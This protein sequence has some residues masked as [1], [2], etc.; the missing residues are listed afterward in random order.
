MSSPTDGKR[1]WGEGL[2]VA[3]IQKVLAVVGIVGVAVLISVV[4]WQLLNLLLLAFGGIMAAVLFHFLGSKLANTTRLPY[5]AALLTVAFGL[6]LFVGVIIGMTGPLLSNQFSDIST[7][8]GRSLE[9][10]R[11]QIAQWPFGERLVQEIDKFTGPDGFSFEQLSKVGGQFLGILSTTLGT[12]V[13]L[14]L[15]FLLGVYL[16]VEPRLYVGGILRLVPIGHRTRAQEVLDRLYS[17]LVYWFF[18]QMVSL[19]LIG[20]GM[21][22]GLYVL[23][24]PLALFLGLLTAMLTFIPNLGPTLAAVPVMLVALS[25]GPWTALYALIFVI[26]LQNAEGIFVTP[27]ILRRAVQLP[28]ALV[29]TVQICLATLAGFLG[30]LLATPLLVCIIVLVQMLYVHDILGDEIS[31]AA[32][33]GKKVEADGPCNAD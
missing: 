32:K 18:G 6:L 8:F 3:F 4:I 30:L 28:P 33:M 13:S 25:V 19:T 31:D 22:I 5:M 27:T 20:V 17:S 12:V 7:E 10:A 24:V 15:I 11:A 14:L 26:A 9:G 16:A 29:I 1:N 23:G 2:D 21:T